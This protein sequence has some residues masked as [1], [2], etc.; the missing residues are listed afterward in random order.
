M[1]KGP[2]PVVSRGA[3]L[4]LAIALG[5]QPVAVRAAAIDDKINQHQHQVHNAHVKL[6]A[7]KAQLAGARA[8]VGSLQGQLDETNHNIA[9]V[10]V[11]LDR[12]TNDVHTNENRL[13]VNKVQLDAAEATLRRHNDAY[14]RRLVDAYEHGNLGYINVLLAA[15]SFADFVERWDDLRY[16]IR[17]N[18]DTIRARQ[19]AQRQ[20]ADARTQ[21]LGTQ[22]ALER[23][24]TE[25]QRK[26][27]ELDQLAQQR[28]NLLGVAEAER[29]AVAH[30][31]NELE[32]ISEQEEAALEVLIREKQRI[33]A[34]RRAE[35][36]R[37]ALLA[38]R[39]VPS[40]A[41]GPGAVG[42]PVSG[43]ITSPFGMRFDPVQHRYQ[44]HSGIDIAAAQGTTISAA[45]DGRVIFAGWYGGY[46]NAI[47]IDHGGGTST[48]YGH[49]SQMFVGVGQDVQRGQAIGAVGMTGDATGPHVHFEVRRDG[50]PVDPLGYLH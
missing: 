2:A 18:Q 19:A 6:N 16:V 32:E 40:T 13:T 47:V 31:V 28:R 29:T 8:K 42:W 43:P 15:N 5:I 27:N 34:A 39:P 22:V 38:G 3:A 24:Q 33:E 14:R 48:L 1:G 46:G 11:D 41:V 45:A 50:K 4:L 25:Q 44:L 36:R 49:C 7:K 21:L 37:A 26:R 20:V 9:V 35:E 17:A 23:S 30:Q 12:V 10:S